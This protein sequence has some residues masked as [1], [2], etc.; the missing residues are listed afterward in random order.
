MRRVIRVSECQKTATAFVVFRSGN[1]TARRLP[2]C[3]CRCHWNGD[4]CRNSPQQTR[5]DCHDVSFEHIPHRNTKTEKSEVIA[6]R[7]ALR[8]QPLTV[9]HLAVSHITSQRSRLP[10][11][12]RLL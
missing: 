5:H 10:Y 3:N 12:I 7:I 2:V 11:S 9:R 1:E 8:G 6:P 4:N